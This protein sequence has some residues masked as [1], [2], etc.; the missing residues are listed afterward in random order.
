MKQILYLGDTSLKGA[1]SYLAGIMV[2]YGYNFDYVPSNEKIKKQDI[3]KRKLFI[4]SDYSYNFMSKEAEEKIINQVLDGAGFLMIG[5]WESFH[6]STG[7][8]DKSKIAG[9]LPV[10]I[11]EKDDRISCF[12]PAIIIKKKEH[13]ILENLPLEKSP[14]IG[15]FNSLTPKNNSSVLLDVQTFNVTNGKSGLE[16]KKGKRYPLLIVNEAKNFRTSCL[17]TDVAPHWVGGFVDW[18][19][20]RVTAKAKGAEQIEVGNYYAE[21]FSNLISWTGKL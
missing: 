15:G 4:L 20:K 2:H 1:A 3:G 12:Q 17:A 7:Y 6:G 9:L 16:F 18:G 19:N 8:W 5:G 14:S 11:S 10:E 21:F 13:E